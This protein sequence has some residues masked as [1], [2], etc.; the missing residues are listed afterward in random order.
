MSAREIKRLT[1]QGF[2]IDE[3]GSSNINLALISLRLALKAYFSTYKSFSYRIRALDAQHG[4]TEEEIIF[5]HRPA[6]CEAYAECI[7]HFQHFAELTCKGFLRNDHQLLADSVIKA[8]ELLYKLVHKKKLTVEEE[9]K[10]F[11]AE[12]GESLNR[13]KEL[14]KSGQLKGSNKLGFILEYYDALVQLNSL[15][16]RVWHRGLYVLKYTALDEFVGRYLLPYVVATLKHP[17]FKGEEVNWK[18][19]SLACGTDPIAEIVKHFKDQEYDLGKVAFLK[20]MGRAAYE[21]RL[22]PVVKKGTKSKLDKKFTFGAIFGSRRRERAERI[23]ESEAA[24]DYN[25]V[26]ECPVC[27]A[28]SL[29]VHEETDFDYDEETDEP[30]NYRRYTHEVHCENCTFTLEDAVK[31]AADYGIHGIKDFFVT[32]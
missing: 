5:N 4:S 22:P 30:I 1:E 19:R 32:D 21:N 26:T 20:E 3:E 15:R 9:Q 27:G 11:S 16:N 24:L 18:Y 14:V 31:N 2:K 10:L 28:K 8:P 7:V 13:L 17:M 29:I 12:F 25:H 23:A 6:Y